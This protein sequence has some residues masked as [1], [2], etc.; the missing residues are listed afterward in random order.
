MCSGS[1]AG[2]YSRLIDFGIAHL[3]AEEQYSRD[4]GGAPGDRDTPEPLNARLN[5][6]LETVSSEIKKKAEGKGNARHLRSFRFPPFQ[7]L[8]Y[9]CSRQHLVTE[10]S[11][12]TVPSTPV[13]ESTW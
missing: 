2:S 12:M 7:W 3:E 6:R 5:G 4:G 11:T 10:R 8:R 1:G 9:P 13:V